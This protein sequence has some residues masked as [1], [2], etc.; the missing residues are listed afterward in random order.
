VKNITLLGP[1]SSKDIINKFKLSKNLKLPKGHGISLLSI[2]A[3]GFIK[4]GCKV[5]II[6]LSDYIKKIK[7]FFLTKNLKII[8][9]PLRPNGLK[10]N[11]KY[12]GRALDFFYREIQ[13]LKKAINISNTN[14]I[15]AHW[16]YEYAI[17][18]INSKKKYSIHIRDIAHKIFFFHLDFYRFIRFLMNLY[19]FIFGKN[20]IANSHY[21]KK[22]VKCYFNRKI[23]V[24]YNPVEFINHKFKK[25]KFNKKKLKILIVTSGGMSKR[26][27]IENGIFAFNLLLKKYPYSSLTLI[28]SD[29]EKYGK[30]YNFCKK[31]NLLKN[32]KFTGYIN[33]NKVINFMHKSDILL[34]PSLEESF[35]RNYIDAMICKLPIIAGKYSGATK[36]IVDKNGLLVDVRN[37]NEIYK[38]LIYYCKNHLI[39]K[40]ISQNSYEYVK[41]FDYKNITKKYLNLLMKFSE[42]K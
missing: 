21:T 12:L 16:T 24:I 42:N 19:V 3:K 36:E 6:I 4:N 18:A 40:K 29:T 20:F 37:S 25:K 34:N 27:N 9:C 14:F 32:I 22:N 10:F 7:N 26:K 13:Y 38:A 41:K 30:Y 23:S 33:H 39:Y 1:V 28:G 35:G 8:F 15:C 2:L 5:T 11:G 17:A 31:N